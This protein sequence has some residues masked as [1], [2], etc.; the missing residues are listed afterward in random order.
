MKK[1]ITRASKAKK[2]LES[3]NPNQRVIIL[4]LED[5]PG[6]NLENLDLLQTLV[7]EELNKQFERLVNETPAYAYFLASDYF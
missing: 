4:V 2:Q 1:I 5:D 7:Q 3:I 6:V